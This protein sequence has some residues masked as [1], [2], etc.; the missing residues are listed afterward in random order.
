MGKL[1]LFYLLVALYVSY[2][3]LFCNVKN[4][5]ELAK[6]FKPNEKNINQIYI[7]TIYE[8]KKINYCDGSRAYFKY[9]GTS[10]C[11]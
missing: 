4:Y 1:L 7:K 10:R 9:I 3:F 6:F 8:I 2:Y 5:S 11:V